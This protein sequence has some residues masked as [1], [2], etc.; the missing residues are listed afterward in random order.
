[1]QKVYFR[2]KFLVFGLHLYI[3]ITK[4]VHNDNV[5]SGNSFLDKAL[6]AAAL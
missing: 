3:F 6:N 2:N 4:L 5:A 1:M